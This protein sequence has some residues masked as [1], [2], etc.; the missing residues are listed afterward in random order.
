MLESMINFGSTLPPTP[1]QGKNMIWEVQE[2][3]LHFL[4]LIKTILKQK[5]LQLPS[6]KEENQL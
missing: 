4:V 5:L 2:F 6:V 3:I 1:K